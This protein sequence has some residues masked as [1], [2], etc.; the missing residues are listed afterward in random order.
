M[1]RLHAERANKKIRWSRLITGQRER[2]QVAGEEVITRY[3]GKGFKIEKRG[4]M[5]SKAKK[6]LG[7]PQCT[8]WLTGLSR[9]YSSPVD[10]TIVLQV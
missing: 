6:G 7:R 2:S 10:S 5:V 4:I 1:A 9:F 8:L 3:Q